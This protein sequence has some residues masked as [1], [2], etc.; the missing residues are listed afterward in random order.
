VTAG[1]PGV[2]Y[3]TQGY[4]GMPMGSAP[5]QQLMAQQPPQSAQA[6]PQLQQQGYAQVP[7]PAGGWVAP[8][9]GGMMYVSGAPAQ[10]VTMPAMVPQGAY[11]QGMQQQQPPQQQP[12][13]QGSLPAGQQPPGTSKRSH[14]YSTTV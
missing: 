11:A 5:P 10:M 12:Q 8:A 6:P 3:T 9:Q 4:G 7:M 13:M 2:A 14:K 1:N